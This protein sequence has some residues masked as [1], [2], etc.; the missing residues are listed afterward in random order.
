MTVRKEDWGWIVDFVMRYPDGTKERIREASEIQ[1]KR[2]AEQWEHLRRQELLDQWQRDKL[3]LNEPRKEVPTFAEWWEGR[4]WRERVI[5][6]RNKPSEMSNKKEI[7]RNY[8]KDRFGGLRLDEIGTE[9]HIADFRASLIERVDRSEIGEKRVNN[10]LVPLSTALRYAEDQEVIDRAPRVR[11]L[12]VER[13]EIQWWEFD[14]YVRVLAAAQREGPFLFAAACLAGEAG[15]RIGEVRGLVWERDLDLVAGTLTV[16]FQRHRDVEGTPK[17][18]KRRKLPMT[19]T[20]IAALKAMPVVRRGYVVRNDDG[21]PL[22]DNQTHHSIGRI[23]RR[24]GLPQRRW[25][26]LRHT[27]GT[28]AA[29]LGV[30]PW[31]LMSW[32]GHKEITTT[33]QYVHV[34]ED[35]HRRLPKKVLE[36][37]QGET[38]PDRRIVLMLGARAWQLCGSNADL[39]ANYSIS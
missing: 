31:R 13:P 29:L 11:L 20:L 18:G 28:H 9:G 19:P 23:C 22:R 8:L 21:S 7:Y 5:G 14:E 26:C 1:T 37:G 36:A 38:D 4:F 33:L 25:H 10:I 3:G 12:K 35:H 27:F 39:K 34:A 6:A 30:N 24:A 15:L 32:M 16:N 2:G 17:G